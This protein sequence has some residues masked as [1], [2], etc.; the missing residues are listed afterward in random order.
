MKKTLIGA[1]FGG[2]MFAV[3]VSAA[4]VDLLSYDNGWYHSNGQHLTNNPNIIDTSRYNNWFAFDLSGVTGEIVSAVLTVFGGN[5][6]Y[7]NTSDSTSY[8]IYDVATAVP[9]LTSG[10]GGV[11]AYNDLGSGDLYGS[12]TVATTPYAQLPMPEVTVHLS[13]ALSDISA[14]LGG[15]F[16]LG[17]TSNVS[18]YLWGGSN[19]LPAAKLTLETAMIS[20]APVP[21]PA[22]GVLLLTAMAGLG[23]LHRRRRMA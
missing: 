23:V 3:P 15:L 22:G 10:G 2:L 21:L 7:Y 6:S 18:H 19:A 13:G 12:A 16:A 4:T 20:P 1:L 11:S 17:G 14:A 8:R 9:V 5:G